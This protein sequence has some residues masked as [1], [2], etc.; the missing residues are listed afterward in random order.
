MPQGKVK[1]KRNGMLISRIV[2]GKVK[3]DHLSKLGKVTAEKSLETARYGIKACDHT[4]QV[5]PLPVSIG[6]SFI[7]DSRSAKSDDRN[8]GLGNAFSTRRSA[9]RLATAPPRL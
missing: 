9:T 7:A 5:N 2:F 3:F 1:I 4:S 6:K 8:L